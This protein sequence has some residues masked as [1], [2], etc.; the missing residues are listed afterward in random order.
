L[1]LRWFLFEELKYVRFFLGDKVV[2][3]MTTLCR[4]T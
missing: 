3:N 4:G 1:K 2:T